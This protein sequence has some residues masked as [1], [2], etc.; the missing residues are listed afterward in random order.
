MLDKIISFLEHNLLTCSWKEYLNQECMGCG[1]QRSII[2]LLKGE[3]I[4]SFKMYPALY[5]L[6]I[7]F[8]FLAFHLRFNFKIGHSVLLYLFYINV[9][10]I[11]VNYFI[12]FI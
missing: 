4:G 9:I 8:V 11:L 2:L 10:I 6:I 1:M 3:I 12:K 7:M 5:T